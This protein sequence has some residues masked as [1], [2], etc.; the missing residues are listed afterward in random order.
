[1]R[2]RLACTCA[3]GSG[4]PIGVHR[5]TSRA[6]DA[7]TCLHL[8]SITAGSGCRHSLLQALAGPEDSTAW[9]TSGAADLEREL[10]QR[11]QELG[12][13][14]ARHAGRTAAELGADAAPAGGYDADQLTGPLKVSWRC[15]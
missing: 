13:E 14:T 5:L 11:Q 15:G 4:V 10:A 8:S 6:V 7:L 9:M 1:M 3:A 12:A 2:L